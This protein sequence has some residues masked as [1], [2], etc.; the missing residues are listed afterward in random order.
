MSM[1]KEELADILGFED[2][3]KGFDLEF[4]TDDSIDFLDIYS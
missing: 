3:V 4:M 1:H 2:C